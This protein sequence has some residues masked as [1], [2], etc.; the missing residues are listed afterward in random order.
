[1]HKMK[2]ILT[3]PASA[4]PLAVPVPLPSAADVSALPAVSADPLPGVLEVVRVEHGVDGGL[5][6]PVHPH[7]A[8]RVQ[9]A[10]RESRQ[11]RELKAGEVTAGHLGP[12]VRLDQVK[13]RVDVVLEGGAVPP[14][15]PELEL[16][17]VDCPH[18]AQA[19][20]VHKAGIPFAKFD[21]KQK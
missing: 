15:L 19:D 6:V 12:E 3:F 1:M 4:L 10:A 18:C 20:R 7:G 5:G 14:P 11:P 16:A 9:R 13:V 17:F 8:L 21:L 2:E